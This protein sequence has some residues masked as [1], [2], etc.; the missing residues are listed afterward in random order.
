MPD[1]GPIHPQVVHFVVALLFVGVIARLVSLAVMKVQWLR[2][3]GPMA[4][5]LILLG[6]AASVVAV[7]SGDDAHGPAERVP[8]AREAVVVHEEAGE[9][10]RNI[11]LVVAAVEILALA[12][13]K[14]QK[15]VLGLHL[16]SVLVA[17]HGLW[18]LYEAA[19]HGG[20]LVY[21]YAGGVGLRSGDSAD[22]RR[23]L[24][25][26]LYHR[27]AQQRRAGRGAAAARLTDELALQMPGDLSVRLL[28]I[29]SRLTDR[30]DAAGALAMLDSLVVPDS[31]P[32]M[33][34]MTGA[35]RVEALAAAG[36]GDSA[37]ALLGRLKAEFPQSRRVTELEGKLGR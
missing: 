9:L 8:G 31:V 15:V 25:A 6:T 36:Q 12:L 32:R 16:A 26:G 18:A 11:F 28:Q 35:L 19:E 5:L 7:Q 27:A 30:G 3:V 34:L 29:E 21:S 20:E 10:A 14:K 23:L 4:A 17:T 22:V 1:L 33:R 2:W 24:V 13:R 37:R